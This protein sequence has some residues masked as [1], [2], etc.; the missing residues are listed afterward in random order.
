MVSGML[1]LCCANPSLVGPDTVAQ[2]VAMLRMRAEF[3]DGYREFTQ[4]SRS[5]VSML[6]PVHSRGYRHAVGAVRCPVLAIHGA[7]DRLIPVAA[8]RAAARAHPA[9][10]LEVLPGVGHVPQLEA[11][12]ETAWLVTPGWPGRAARPWR[13]RVR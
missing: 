8:A 12:A 7:R 6:G 4:A 1:G 13:P 11:P 3:T 5:V 2:H 10:T 9:W